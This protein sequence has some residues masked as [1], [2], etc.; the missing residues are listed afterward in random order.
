RAKDTN[1]WNCRV[2]F[3]LGF[4]LF[5]LC[6]NLVWGILHVHRGHINDVGSLAFFFRLLEK[7]RLGNDQPDYHTFLA[8]LTQILDGLL[9]STWRRECGSPSLQAFTESK[10]TAKQLCIVSERILNEFK[11]PSGHPWYLCSRHPADF[12]ELFCEHGTSKLRFS[13]SPIM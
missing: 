6:L 9:L 4:G 1:A 11:R 7:A 2:I 3:Q 13:H 12:L 5:H 10:P 8:A